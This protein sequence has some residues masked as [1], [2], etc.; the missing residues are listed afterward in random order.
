MRVKRRKMIMLLVILNL[1]QQKTFIILSNPVKRTL[2]F[3]VEFNKYDTEKI[4]NVEF[5]YRKRIS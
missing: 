5:S 1:L 2:D 3:V 4:R